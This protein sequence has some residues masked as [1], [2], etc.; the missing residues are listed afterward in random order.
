[1]N[2][3]DQGDINCPHCE[4]S[5]RI[6][7]TL[8]KNTI[9]CS[10]CKKII[11][12]VQSRLIPLASSIDSL[13]S[14]RPDS[15]N[16]NIETLIQE[17]TNQAH[18]P[19]EEKAQ[20][21]V[22]DQES[23][24]SEDFAN[25]KSTEELEFDQD[26]VKK[27]EALAQEFAIAQSDILNWE[28]ENDEAGTR[29][30][31]RKKFIRFIFLAVSLIVTSL[32]IYISFKGINKNNAATKGIQLF[33]ESKN[34]EQDDPQETEFKSFDDLQ[35]TMGAQ[36]L[37]KSVSEALEKFL[38]SEDLETKID[39]SRSSNR[40]SQ[41]MRSHYKN[42]NDGPIAYRRISLAGEEGTG[43]IDGFYIIKVSF[44]DFSILPVVLALEENKIVVDWESFVGY[45]ELTLK[46]FIS[47]K[48]EEPKLF[49]LHANSDD[50]FNFQFSEEEYRCLYL[51]NPEDTESVYGYIKRGS[52]ADGQLSRIA[53][54]GQSIR[55]LTLKLRYPKKIG[56]KTQTII[57][58]IVTSGWLIRE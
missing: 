31:S 5:I 22:N 6:E 9:R 2:Q 45:S 8:K 37:H 46:E 23:A 14:K 54:S 13:P 55:F 38:N 1:M 51:R 34:T 53:E 17:N 29:L 27:Q 56:G 33:F 36:K 47:N 3:S 43:I 15:Q 4:C 40:V 49:R 52:V 32:V 20:N 16:V 24:N 7:D 12:D 21:N 39:L 28:E 50:Y 26:F 44:P 25:F 30:N 35:Q 41:L 10:S 42:N 48:P 58:E 11:D 18:I 57:D 19:T